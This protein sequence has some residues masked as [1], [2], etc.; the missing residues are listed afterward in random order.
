MV[1]SFE[2][3]LNLNR[4]ERVTKEW[5]RLQATETTINLGTKKLG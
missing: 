4:I 2:L 1:V 3:E 5:I